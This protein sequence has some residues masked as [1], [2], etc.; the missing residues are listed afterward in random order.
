MIT[1]MGSSLAI[2]DVVSCA[3]DFE[4][5]ERIAACNTYH[6]EHSFFY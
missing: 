6:M 3:R 1:L 2:R 4:N 5:C